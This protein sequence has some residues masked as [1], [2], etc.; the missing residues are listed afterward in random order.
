MAKKIGKPPDF[1]VLIRYSKESG[2]THVS[3]RLDELD[4]LDAE[5]KRLRKAI[6]E[7]HGQKADDR[8]WED[9]DRLYAAAGLPPVDRRVGDKAAM[10]ENCARFIERRCEGGGWATYQELEAELERLRATIDNRTEAG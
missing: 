3:I 10:L 4:A 9:D 5:L 8:C 6:K 2:M 1:S 7:H